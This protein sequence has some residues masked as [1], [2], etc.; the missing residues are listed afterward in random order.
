M[1]ITTTDP[2][3]L[4][5]RLVDDLI[6]RGYLRSEHWQ[7]AFR[8]EPREN[9]VDRF[10]I[11]N[12]RGDDQWHDLGDSA[13][14]DEAL[15]AVYSNTSLITHYDAS[16]TAI[17]SSS[18]PS[19]MALMLEHL[20]A[21]PRQR[22]RVLEVGVGCGYN[23]ALLCAA[24]GD[25]Q[26]VSIDV[27]PDL[28]R[29]AR[30]ALHRAGHHPHVLTGDGAEGAPEH[31]P[32]DRVIA[33]CGFDRVPTQWCA[34]LAP[35]AVIVVNLGLCLARLTA[36]SDGT[37]SGPIVDY[38]SF[39]PRRPTPDAV[40]P[41][42]RE[43]FAPAS[44]DGERTRQV[45]APQAIDDRPFQALRSLVLPTV[46]QIGPV[47]VDGSYRWIDT[48]TGAWSRLTP[49]GGDHA[50]LA[51]GGPRSV[52]DDIA[53]LHTEWNEHGRPE[54]TRY[55]LTIQPDGTHLLWLDDPDHKLRV[56]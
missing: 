11:P 23:A 47:S 51:E 28:V 34:Q 20:D 33:T 53:A 46:R 31:A 39:M 37:V 15:A 19:L 52:Y 12:P 22:P 4:R 44:T 30:E 17:S 1:T 27:A 18:Q 13:H 2:A 14:R 49:A 5:H 8:A 9:Y 10:A 35:A 3:E 25:E 45:P 50:D 29:C 38:A 54:I 56:L 55:G 40:D 42:V 48:A 36:T 7:Q 6:A 26:V 21:H 41:A 32:F 16:G 24:L 43:L